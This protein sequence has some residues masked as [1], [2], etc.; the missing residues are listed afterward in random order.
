MKTKNMPR[1]ALLISGLVLL[2]ITAAS[3]QQA[4]APALQGSVLD[5][6]G[7][8]GQ[9][10][11][12]VGNLSPVEHSNGYLQSY[13]EQDAAIFASPSGSLS[14]TP[15]VSLGMVMDTKGYNWNKKV[16]PQLGVKLNKLFRYGVVSIGSA[17]SY[18][19]RFN[20]LQSSGF[21][22]YAQD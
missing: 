15:Y 6:M 21:I 13:V 2:L 8:P 17:Y 5:G 14:L 19:D 7:L 4:P 3:A 1:T 9:M 20:S 12:T 18:E 11:T 22:F 16:E 10:W